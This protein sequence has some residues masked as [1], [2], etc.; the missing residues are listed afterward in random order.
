[1]LKATAALATTSFVALLAPNAEGLLFYSRPPFIAWHGKTLAEHVALRDRWALQGY[2]FLSL[3]IYARVSAPM[4]AAVMIKRPVVVAQRDWPCMTA[5][6]LQQTFDEQAAQ[7]FGPV[8]LA[9]TG[10]A[11]DPRF[12]AVFQPQNP[13]PLTRYGLTLGNSDDLGTIQ[14]MNDEAKKRW[15]ASYGS[16]ADL[17]FAAI[18]VPN[19]GDVLWNSD[20]LIDDADT[21][22]ARSDAE[23]SVWSRPGFVTLNGQNR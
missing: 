17:R 5:A 3:S 8:I 6:Q 15:A 19:T 21:Y 1:M 4:Y 13:I 18:W 9:A 14:G 10:S 23:T 2:R 16:A 7:G 12:A 22:Q 20:G 11:S